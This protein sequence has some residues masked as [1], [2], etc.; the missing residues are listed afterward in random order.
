M[1][2]NI[3]SSFCPKCGKPVDMPGLCSE[4]RIGTTPW[5][6]CDNRV[7]STNCPS[8][9]ATK[10]VNT[11][12]DTSVERED[13]APEVARSAVHFHPEV[14][15]PSI[16]VS[17]RDLSPNRSRA[18]LVVRGTLYRK[19]MEGTCSVEIRWQKEQCDR[20]NRLSGSYHE[21]VVQVRAEG[22]TPSMFE[23]QTSAS[24]AQQIED[25]LQSGGERL[26]FIADMNEIHDGLDIVVGSQHIGL[27][28]AQGIVAQLGGQYTTHPKLVGEKNGRQLFRITY[29]V[30]L[31]R[32]QKNDVVQSRQ[33]YFEVQ[34]VESRSLQAIDL[35]DGSTRS[36]RKDDISRIIG[37][38]RNAERGLV[39]YADGKN[40]G[41]IDPASSRTKEYPQPG[42]LDVRAG[43]YIR[44]LHD[45]DSMVFVG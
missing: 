13:L 16:E 42:W 37:N 39:A 4:C 14:K 24:I 35:S 5:F 1:K 22:R 21:G 17:V 20:C 8:C 38:S 25:N 36:I 6:T 32:Y 29:S 10:V 28:I 43:D 33:R 9:G 15:K 27:L 19:P 44:L 2:K 23:I 26:S 45:G 12:T 18:S 11:W 30:R 31:P 7:Q 41:V 34:R 40:M 3:Q